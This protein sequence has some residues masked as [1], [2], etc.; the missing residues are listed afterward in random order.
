MTPRTSLALLIALA[1]PLTAQAQDDDD[2]APLAPLGKLKPKPKPKPKPPPAKP[3]PKPATDTG[4]GD[5]DLAPLA[6]L[7][8][9][10][11]VN[12][13][14]PAN[15]SGAVLSVDGKEVGALPLP[16]QSISSGEHTITVK[17][18]GYAAFVKKVL[19][20]GGK[21]L[22]VDAKLTAVS[23]V[24]SV[25]SDVPGAQVLFNGRAIGTVPLTDVE[26]PPGPAEVAVYREGFREQAQKINF[27][28]GKEYP[29]VVKFEA[30]T[31]RPVASKLTPSSTGDGVP[32]TGVSVAPSE[33]VTSK[34]YFWAGIV[35]GAVA[36]GAGVAAGAVVADNNN[37]LTPNGICGGD[38]CDGCIGLACM[39]AA[40]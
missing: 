34:W 14:V 6:P 9:K 38:G 40:K 30:L 7:A 11:D 20:S 21:T 2:L 13:K 28:L 36:I 33:P 10:G 8:A 31:D 17:K 27:Q 15:L 35:A 39:A 12:V 22:D 37:R 32:I 3:R 18:P 26:V 25:T 24:L 1:L 5:D 4:G 19:V 16:P 23:A 29:I